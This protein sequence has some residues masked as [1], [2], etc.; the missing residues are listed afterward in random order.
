MEKFA[1]FA[2]QCPSHIFDAF[3]AGSLS[4]LRAGA[5]G[6]GG[7]V[8][9]TFHGLVLSWGFGNVV[10]FSQPVFRRV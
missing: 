9:K 4:A 7:R 8:V 1:A 5:Y 10:V 3:P 2:E 6:I